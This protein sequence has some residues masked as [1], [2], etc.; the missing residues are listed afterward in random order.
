MKKC[1]EHTRIIAKSILEIKKKKKMYKIKIKVMIKERMLD[2]QR[3]HTDPYFKAE[4]K[5]TCYKIQKRK[6]DPDGY[7]NDF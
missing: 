3:C 5:R 6:M 2:E 7:R 4:L 1:Y